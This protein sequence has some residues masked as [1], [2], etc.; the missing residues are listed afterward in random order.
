MSSSG[1]GLNFGGDT[2]PGGGDLLEFLRPLFIDGGSNG[3][4]STGGGGRVV[5]VVGGS[6]DFWP[7]SSTSFLEEEEVADK[8]S[9][10]AIDGR[11]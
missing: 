6:G 4:G 3:I 5:V 7:P 9:G 8:S 11:S 2:V 10:S 1:S